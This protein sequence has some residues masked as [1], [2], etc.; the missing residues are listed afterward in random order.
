MFFKFYLGR[1]QKRKPN[2]KEK[3]QTL[4]SPLDRENFLL[5]DFKI[6]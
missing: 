5:F 3:K 4:V 6:H 2:C 1:K